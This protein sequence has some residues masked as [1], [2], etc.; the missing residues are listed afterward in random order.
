M[1]QKRIVEM[2]KCIGSVPV[3]NVNISLCCDVCNGV[4]SI[5]S[6]LKFESFATPAHTTIQRKRRRT[7]KLSKELSEQL[8]CSLLTERDT[9][10]TENPML[11]FVGPNVVCP[12]LYIESL[13][14]AAH[15][16]QSQDDP[17]LLRLKPTL[18]T[19]FFKVIH[20]FMSHN[21]SSKKACLV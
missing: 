16:I 14:E 1:F 21:T 7:G 17:H 20:N 6:S 15:S 11:R 12:T 13:C 2:L 18:R 5:Q 8:K 4:D 9:F 19:Q 3:E 10:M